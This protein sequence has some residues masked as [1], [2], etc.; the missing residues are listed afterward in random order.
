MKQIETNRLILRN[1]KLEDSKDLFDY[2]KSDLVGPNAGWPPH[3]NEETSKIIL[4][5]FI[6]ED[7]VYAIELKEN[8]KVIGS[9]GIHNRIPKEALKSFNQREIGYVLHPDYWG[10][11]YMTEAVIRA[12]KYS[13]EELE[14]DI[15]W[16]AH[17]DFNVKSKSVIKRC[18]FKYVFKELKVYERL[19]NKKAM[20][21]YYS[22]T[23][24][25][26]IKT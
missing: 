19:N 10:N 16:C 21:S 1:W 23:R 18:G 9:L 26:Y 2:A 24:A 12:I 17:A 6:K 20:L 14:I 3:K 4:N 15:L 25:D 7:D 8:H 13:F 5:N 22:I 11:G